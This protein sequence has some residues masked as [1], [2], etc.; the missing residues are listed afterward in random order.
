VTRGR[1]VGRVRREAPQKKPLVVEFGEARR[2]FRAR[3]LIRVERVKGAVVS[4]VIPGWDS[5]RVLDV[6]RSMLP[7][8]WRVRRGLRFFCTVNL[9]AEMAADL[10]PGAPFELGGAPARIVTTEAKV[11]RAV[12]AAPRSTN[13][14]KASPPK[15]VQKRP[16]PMPL[17]RRVAQ[18]M[19]RACIK[20]VGEEFSK[21]LDISAQDALRKVNVDSVIRA[22]LATWIGDST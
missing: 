10:L 15:K 17:L 5:A 2:S 1:V 9:A 16:V 12:R 3:Q 21:D 11:S 19:K 18:A 6:S 13:F 22:V 14:R 20:R 4:L 8:E 7:S